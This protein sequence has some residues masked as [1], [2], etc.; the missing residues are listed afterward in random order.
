[1]RIIAESRL[2]RMVQ[3]HG[4]CLDQV[5]AWVHEVR[6]AQWHSLMEV[7]RTYRHADAV[8]DLTVFN[9]KGNDYR[10]VVGIDYQW[11]CVYI[12]HLLTHAE[13]D[14]EDWKKQ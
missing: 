7:R 13:Y 5:T 3:E 2:K 6:A 1:M 12:K 4:D 10:L 8:G 9:I 11:G 14:K